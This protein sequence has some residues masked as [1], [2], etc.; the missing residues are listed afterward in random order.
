MGQAPSAIRRIGERPAPW[1]ASRATTTPA[2]AGT[3]MKA[4]HT[5]LL[6]PTATVLAALIQSKSAS[7]E[8]PMVDVMFGHVYRA[9]ET[10]IRW[11]EKENRDGAPPPSAEPL[12]L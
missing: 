4:S 7:G 1:Q 12:K 11:I 8:L 5:D 6:Q 9:I 3:L 10:A 2:T